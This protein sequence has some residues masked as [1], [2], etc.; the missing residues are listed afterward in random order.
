MPVV[1]QLTAD[2]PIHV[3]YNKTRKSDA[4]KKFATAK[5]MSE[6]ASL[7]GQGYTLMEVARIMKKNPGYIYRLIDRVKR[8]MRKVQ[9]IDIQDH[10]NL[11][12][13]QYERII[14]Q[15]WEAWEESKKN[16]KG[17]KRN[18]DVQ[19]LDRILAALEHIR[20]MDGLDKKPDIAPE[21][22][23]RKGFD[24]DSLTAGHQLTSVTLGIGEKSIA[25]SPNKLDLLKD[26]LEERIQELQRRADE[27][28]I[29]ELRK[30][31]A[32]RNRVVKLK[33]KRNVVVVVSSKPIDLGDE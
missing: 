5:T 17:E 30:D 9:M 12:R 7:L 23:P 6:C 18:A 24:W 27:K 1:G 11:R 4:A 29:Q 13:M 21:D 3:D 19:Y 26:E 14:S 8:R 33:T 25:P 20:K 22:N 2:D 16:H 15:C 28:Q 10:L 32:D 31:E